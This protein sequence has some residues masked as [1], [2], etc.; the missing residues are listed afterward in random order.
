[1]STTTT[2]LDA[3]VKSQAEEIVTSGADIRP[4]LADVVSQAAAQSQQSG[5]GL[6]SLIRAVIDGA[7]E[8]LV[9]SVPKD[10]DDALRQVVDALGDG[11]SRTALAGQLAVQETLSSSRQFA[12]E[13]LARLRDDLTAVH[14]LFA[15]TVG[16]GLTSGKALTTGQISSAMTHAG[17]VA[18][19]LGPV[20]TRALDAARQHP[21]T[22]ARE[23]LQAG[24]SAGQGAA[25]ALF[26]AL[27]R[28][29]QQ[30]GD[31]LRREGPPDK[32]TAG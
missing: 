4:R 3:A 11:L 22:L 17:R 18:E 30:A 2:D 7:H 15:E 29:L 24:V 25:G 10:R 32:G 1:M 21:V 16:R 19:R 28:L 26:Q 6:V 5:Q 12:S 20:F 23:G 27:G 13:D 31:Q 8:G 9:R 14:S